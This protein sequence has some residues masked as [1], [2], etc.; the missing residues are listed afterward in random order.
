MLRHVLGVHQGLLRSGRSSFRF[1]LAWFVPIRSGGF[2][3]SAVAFDASAWLSCVGAKA[4]ARVVHILRTTVVSRG[5]KVEVL[6]VSYEKQANL[7]ED[8]FC[9]ELRYWCSEFAGRCANADPKLTTSWWL[10]TGITGT[11]S[12]RRRFSPL[13][14]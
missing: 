4:L 6:L 7:I 1:P 3:S 11:C 13:R 10:R 14:R 12:T 9:Y 2:L 8:S 5:N